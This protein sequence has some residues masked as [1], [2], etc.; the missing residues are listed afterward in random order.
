MVIDLNACIG[1]G[2]CVIACQVENNIPVVGREEVLYA[3]EMHWI[4]FDRYYLGDPKN[5]KVVFQ[6]MMCQHCDY[7]PCEAVC[8]VSAPMEP[9]KKATFGSLVFFKIKIS[10][11]P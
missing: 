10:S 1:C 7:A 2:A 5:P 8:P 9:A 11:T 3:R 6:P 4:R